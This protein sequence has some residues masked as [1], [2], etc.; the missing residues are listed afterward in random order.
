ML[1][2][3]KSSVTRRVLSILLAAVLVFGGTLGSVAHAS[4]GIVGVHAHGESTASV[5]DAAA[6]IWKMIDADQEFDRSPFSQHFESCLDLI[7]H[8]GLAILPCI[9]ELKRAEACAIFLAPSGFAGVGRA[10]GPLDRP[11]LSLRS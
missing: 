10:P 9:N 5:S 8:G 11:P 6:S 4:H 7:C 2:I 1:A 3:D